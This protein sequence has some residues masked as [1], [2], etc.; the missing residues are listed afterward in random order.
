MES[1]CVCSVQNFREVVSYKSKMVRNFS[2]FCFNF[3]ESPASLAEQM[4]AQID[5]G[6][7]FYSIE[8]TPPISVL[9]SCQLLRRY[10]NL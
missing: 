2:K 3:R 8:I 6:D 1:D 5:S 9:D 10:L 4:H 7:K